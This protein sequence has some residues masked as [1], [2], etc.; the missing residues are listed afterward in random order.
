MMILGI[1]RG[2]KALALAIVFGGVALTEFI[3]YAM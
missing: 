1:P 3:N 2:T